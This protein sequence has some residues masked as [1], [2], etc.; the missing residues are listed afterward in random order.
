MLLQTA[1]TDISAEVA[2]GCGFGCLQG[3]EK[4][5]ARGV[6]WTDG[7]TD[8]QTDGRT[9]GEVL[10]RDS[11]TLRLSCVWKLPIIKW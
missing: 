6:R 3:T 11:K 4:C 1:V 2:Q 8:G 10:A 7:R 5:K 9:G